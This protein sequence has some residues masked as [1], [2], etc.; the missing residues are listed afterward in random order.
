MEE[1]G[2]ETVAVLQAQASALHRKVM[3][4]TTD[5]VTK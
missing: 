2:E 1:E 5:S 4:Y 3:A